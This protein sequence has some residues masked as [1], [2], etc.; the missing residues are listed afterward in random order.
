M[1]DYMLGAKVRISVAIT[2]VVSNQLADPSELVLKIRPPKGG[3]NTL[4]YGV[5][6]ALVRAGVGLYNAEIDLTMSGYWRW[7]WEAS[8]PNAGVVEGIL[9][10]NRSGVL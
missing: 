8:A 10:V 9:N 1:S 5:D 4:T 6:A 7:R 3:L 2:D